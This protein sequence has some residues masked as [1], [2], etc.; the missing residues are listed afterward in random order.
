MIK[1]ISYEPKSFK[2]HQTNARSWDYLQ[3]TVS[4]HGII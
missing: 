3:L 4:A 1:A 2:K